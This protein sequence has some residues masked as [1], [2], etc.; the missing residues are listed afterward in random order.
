MDSALLGS[1]FGALL[2]QQRLRRDAG[3]PEEIGGREPCD[4]RR[5]W[6]TQQVG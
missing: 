2:R 5:S 1:A 6:W 3:C 4:D